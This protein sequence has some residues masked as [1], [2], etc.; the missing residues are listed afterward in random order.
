MSGD[1]S[2]PA[3]LDDILAYASEKDMT[4]VPYRLCPTD[5]NR[6][7]LARF[8]NEPWVE[9]IIAA[10]GDG[11]IGSIARLV[12]ETKPSLPLG[13]IPSGTLND[14]AES[15]PS[16]LGIWECIDVV[17]EGFTRRFDVGRVNG[18]RIFLSTCAAGM[19]VNVSFSTSS[20]LKKSLG[21]LAYYFAALG[22]IPN[23]R[24]FPLRIETES[25]V[26]EDNFLLFL[27][28]NGTHAAGMTNLYSKAQMEDGFMDLLLIR[29]VPPIEL[30]NL[31]IEIIN[32]ENIDEGRWYK[33]MRAKRFRFD[34][35]STILSTQ[36]G[37]EGLSLPLDVEVLPQAL[38][39]FVRK[40]DI[41]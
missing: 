19:F 18:E 12:L 24:A 21:P 13:I 2:V 8:I 9:F 37:E 34:G 16:P 31:F 3:A 11:T 26:V 25:E 20:M 27:L 4:L 41:D 1:Q 35:P 28:I 32:R 15:V 5:E 39:V 6:D 40:P 14:F 7:F 36:D 33:R 30:P 17:A 10:G 22:E 29:D 38:T 23:I